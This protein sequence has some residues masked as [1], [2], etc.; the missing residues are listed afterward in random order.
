[1]CLNALEQFRKPPKSQ[2]L[3]RLAPDALLLGVLLF[4][5]RSR[6]CPLAQTVGNLGD[7]PSP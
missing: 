3:L 5:N 6:Q 2:L 4:E 1:M 7:L